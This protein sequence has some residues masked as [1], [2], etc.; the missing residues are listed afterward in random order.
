MKIIACRFQIH[1]RVMREETEMDNKSGHYRETS[2]SIRKMGVRAR[3]HARNGRGRGWAKRL[4]F[5]YSLFLPQSASHQ[6]A[7]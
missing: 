7:P 6:S 4:N 2:I 5:N 1:L 3:T